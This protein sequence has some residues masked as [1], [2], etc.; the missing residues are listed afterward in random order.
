MRIIGLEVAKTTAQIFGD[1]DLKPTIIKTG[2]NVS[3]SN[4]LIQLQKKPIF[5]M[6]FKFK[7]DIAHYSGLEFLIKDIDTKANYHVISTTAAEIIN[8]LM[9][10]TIP[11]DKEGNYKLLFKIAKSGKSTHLLL[12]N[13]KDTD[14]MTPI[15]MLK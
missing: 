2:Y 10:D 9:L 12:A 15:G 3:K 11:K 4:G 8:M 14:K 5:E 1:H 6:K 7:G 13:K